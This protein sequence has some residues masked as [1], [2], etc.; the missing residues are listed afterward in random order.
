MYCRKC[1]KNNAENAK[2]CIGCGSILERMTEK[3]PE[4]VPEPLKEKEQAQ[5]AGK[6]KKPIN[7]KKVKLAVILTVALV[8]VISAVGIGSAVYLKLNSPLVKISRGFKDLLTSG[9]AHKYK[10]S[11]DD[12]YLREI[13]CDFK[14][15]LKN[16][17]FEAVNIKAAVYD[18]ASQRLSKINDG[19][20]LLHINE[21][22]Y[23]SVA[24]F[25][26]TLSSSFDKGKT[27]KYNNY[28]M[29]Y[30]DGELKNCRPTF[31]T[32]RPGD[33]EKYENSFFEILSLLSDFTNG[34]KSF[35]ETYGQLITVLDDNGLF[36][37][38]GA[39]M[40]QIDLA[41]GV[42]DVFGIGISSLGDLKS[43]K[44]DKSINKKVQKELK[45][46]LTDEKWLEENLGLKV[47]KD[48]KTIVYK[49]DINV[50]KAGKALFDIFKPLL[51]DLYN[52]IEQI[53]L[54]HGNIWMA[55][56]NL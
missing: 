42:E 45:K 32:Y 26:S 40:E 55:V 22:E 34:T 4:S 5:K 1:G 51:E 30:H 24:D 38:D 14:A 43:V 20:T 39:Y 46:C 50:G 53:D 11:F 35:E 48:G 8:L 18:T 36:Y 15:D 37:P 54:C 21:K 23:I 9:E 13:E 44:I 12:G 47:S 28:S 27:I 7:V 29:T 2:F 25:S 49:F 33:K 56:T 31:K 52:Q 19:Y 3:E 10:V 41:D 16:K 17:K 6:V